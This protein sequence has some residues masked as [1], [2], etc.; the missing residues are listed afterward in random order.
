MC[1]KGYRK[2]HCLRGHPRTPENLAT[3]NCRICHNEARRT[4]RPGGRPPRQGKSICKYGPRQGKS[5]CKYGHDRTPNGGGCKRCVEVRNEAGKK[6]RAERRKAAGL[7]LW[8]GYLT[9]VCATCGTEFT[10]CRSQKT[11]RLVQK[12]RFGIDDGRLFCSKSCS[13]AGR[14]NGTPS[15]KRLKKMPWESDDQH[16]WNQVLSDSGLGEHRGVRSWIEYGLHTF[17]ENR[18]GS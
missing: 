5:I 11:R 18:D 12:K 10:I 17:V 9:V 13:G 3:N 14:A 7:G 6:E 16:H 15:G 2:S 1:F 8:G 4:G